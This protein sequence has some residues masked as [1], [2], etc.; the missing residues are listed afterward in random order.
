MSKMLELL[1]VSDISQLELIPFDPDNIS[2]S[3]EGEVTPS[4]N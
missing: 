4:V 2:E 3:E 1:K